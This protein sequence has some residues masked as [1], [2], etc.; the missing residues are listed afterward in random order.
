M[1]SKP[2][3]WGRRACRAYPVAWSSAVAA[4]AGG[5]SAAGPAPDI[6]SRHVT[7]SCRCPDSPPHGSHGS[8]RERRKRSCGKSWSSWDR[9]VWLPM[10]AYRGFAQ[11]ER[12]SHKEA[13]RCML[14]RSEGAKNPMGKKHR[15]DQPAGPDLVM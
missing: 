4:G 11:R 2:A 12:L 8:E 5:R 13:K 6:T 15:T 14:R 3:F 7:A 1:F 10:A 9:K